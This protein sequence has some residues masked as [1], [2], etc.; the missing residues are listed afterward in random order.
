MYCVITRRFAGIQQELAAIFRAV[1]EVQVITD[2]R[3]QERRRAQVPVTQDRRKLAARR[4]SSPVAVLLAHD[5]LTRLHGEST[6]HRASM[7]VKTWLAVSIATLLCIVVILIGYSLYVYKFVQD[8]AGM[9]LI[10]AHQLGILFF[11]F[12]IIIVGCSVRY[13]ESTHEP[14]IRRMG[15]TRLLWTGYRTRIIR[16]MFWTGI[17]LMTLGSALQW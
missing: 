13:F 3:L 10:G 11:I 15:I 4:L 14:M 12:G 8:S 1:P 16:W 6:T 7:S 5:V 2:R 17:I 9:L